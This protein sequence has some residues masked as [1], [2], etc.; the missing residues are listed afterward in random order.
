MTSAMDIPP[1]HPQKMGEDL[2]YGDVAMDPRRNTYMRQRE[3]CQ[4]PLTLADS[5]PQE[6][7]TTHQTRSWLARPNKKGGVKWV[8]TP[9][10]GGM[11]MSVC[12]PDAEYSHPPEEGPSLPIEGWL[13]TL[14][15]KGRETKN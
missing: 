15:P 13:H 9:V 14:H 6:Y 12:L 7:M 2:R 4:G 10:S 11:M 3:L 5:E 8:S 1:E